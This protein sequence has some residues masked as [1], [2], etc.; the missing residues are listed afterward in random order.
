MK[1]LAT[2]PLLALLAVPGPVT[3]LD[4]AGDGAV[5][6]GGLPFP[7][8]LDAIQA[9]VFTPGCALSFCHG[10][11]R[12]AELDLREGAS[13]GNLVNVPSLQVPTAL[14]VEPFAPDASYLICKL[15]SCPGMLGG[16]MPP[17]PAPLDPGVIAVIRQWV[18]EGAHATVAVEGASWGQVKSLYR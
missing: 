7:P 18:A 12:L 17:F 3:A 5:I 10:E 6:A 8:S 15:E 4:R 2:I 1:R 9:N 13:W 16:Q 14:R 11:A